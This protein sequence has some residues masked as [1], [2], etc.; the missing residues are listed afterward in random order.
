MEPRF[1]PINDPCSRGAYAK[2]ERERE[3]RIRKEEK[4]NDRK[5]GRRGREEMGERE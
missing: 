4:Y 3:S 2:Q 1:F 5:T